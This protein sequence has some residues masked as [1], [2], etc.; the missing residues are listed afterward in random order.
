MTYA[1]IAYG[2]TVVLWIVWIVATLRRERSI[3]E[4]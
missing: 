1:W 4:E 2:V 3:G